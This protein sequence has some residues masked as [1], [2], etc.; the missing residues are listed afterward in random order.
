VAQF[1]ITF[2]VSF[3]AVSWITGAGRK[4][5]RP[6]GGKFK[7]GKAETGENRAAAR[8]IVHSANEVKK[9]RIDGDGVV[10]DTKVER[11][12]KNAV[13]EDNSG[14]KKNRPKTP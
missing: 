9:G 13:W 8:T 3:P 10:T 5:L 2:G 1:S 7:R 11:Q 12:R 4:R 6:R 14:E